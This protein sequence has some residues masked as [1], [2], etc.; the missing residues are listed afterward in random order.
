MRLADLFS[1]RQAG[2]GEQRVPG[3]GFVGEQDGANERSLKE[4]L[5]ILF[6]EQDSVKAAY[7]TRA[8]YAKP[9]MKSVV[10]CV[11]T[12]N[13]PDRIFVETVHRLFRR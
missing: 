2:Q 10:L 1:R 8:R 12:I 4:K 5:S 3:V 7:L 11:V 13:G 6:R 9:E